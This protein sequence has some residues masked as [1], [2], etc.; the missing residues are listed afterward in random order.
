MPN[1]YT[2]QRQ[3]RDFPI[4][5]AFQAAEMSTEANYSNIDGI[6]G[7]N[8]PKD[9]KSLLEQLAQCK[10]EAERNAVPVDGHEPRE[11]GGISR[12]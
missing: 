11:M 5:N 9:K 2:R 4:F 8:D 10:K 3:G 6:L 12:G 7:N 1:E